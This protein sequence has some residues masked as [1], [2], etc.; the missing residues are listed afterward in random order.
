[1]ILH[2]F[3]SFRTV[4]IRYAFRQSK[5]HHFRMYFIRVTP[6]TYR[7]RVLKSFIALQSHTQRAIILYSHSP[8]KLLPESLR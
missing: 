1:M 6:T 5:C 7:S 4:L 8:Q 3:E 2:D